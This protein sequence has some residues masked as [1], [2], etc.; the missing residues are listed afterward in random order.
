MR[1]LHLHARKLI[2]STG[3]YLHLLALKITEIQTA[4]YRVG[5][6][7]RILAARYGSQYFGIFLRM[8]IISIHSQLSHLNDL[9]W[10]I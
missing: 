7:G 6:Q 8:E 5:I 10:S 9:R 4:E 2:H 1:E 3:A